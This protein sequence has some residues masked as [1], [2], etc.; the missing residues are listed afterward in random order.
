MR[1]Q[2]RWVKRRKGA[3]ALDLVES[4]ETTEESPE[5]SE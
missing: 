2:K 1:S 5:L 4:D 3:D